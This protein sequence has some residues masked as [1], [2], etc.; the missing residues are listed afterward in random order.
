MWYVC[1]DA[2]SVEGMAVSHRSDMRVKEEARQRGVSEHTLEKSEWHPIWHERT[3][4]NTTLAARSCLQ[5]NKAGYDRRTSHQSAAG[6]TRTRRGAR[7]SS[8]GAGGSFFLWRSSDSLGTVS[9]WLH[10][11]AAST[12]WPWLESLGEDICDHYSPACLALQ[13]EM[14]SEQ[15]CQTLTILLC[16]SWK[17]TFLLKLGD[18]SEYF[19]V[20]SKWSQPL[21]GLT[22]TSCDFAWDLSLELCT[23]A[24]EGKDI[25][26]KILP[27][28]ITSK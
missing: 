4:S 27:N 6:W 22:P 8:G 2:G 21:W 11:T 15:R 5:A 1:T 10:R 7:A 24:N 28:W 13:G 16:C 3:C 20:E 25:P 12:C 18:R 19:V 26:H 14:M 23:N 9:E 17:Q